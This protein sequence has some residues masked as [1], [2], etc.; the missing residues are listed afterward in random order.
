MNYIIH[1][2][3]SFA[4]VALSALI[5]IP[6]L[7]PALTLAVSPDIVAPTVS[8]T[9]PAAS[10]TVSGMVT[11]SATAADIY[12]SCVV[13]VSGSKY[14]VTPLQIGHPGGNIFVCG[15]DMTALFQSMHGSNL[16]KLAP[17]LIPASYIGVSKVEFL[18]DGT[19]VNTDM[20]SPYSFSWDSTTV[21]NGVHN[22]MAKA[23][24]QG[25]N[26]GSSAAVSV[27]VNN[28][29]PAPIPVLTSIVL[30]PASASLLVGASA[31]FSASARDQFGAALSPQPAFTWLS[32]D[33]GKATV[34]ASGLVTGVAAGSAIVTASS[35]S[36]SKTANITVT[37]PAP[38]P[39][40]AVDLSKVKIKVEMEKG[41]AEVHITMKTGPKPK[42]IE[43]KLKTS[44]KMVVVN[45]IIS[46][47][48]LTAEQVLSIAKFKIHEE[49]EDDEEEQDD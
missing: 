29:A 26:V 3:R 30:S 15:T 46:K 23:Y 6:L 27:T 21:A 49:H 20:S 22:L 18:V 5:A 33:T 44:D 1:K 12:S 2:I 37:A 19:L 32:S 10:A 11:L 28:V 4:L 47:T 42:E 9:A 8:L 7:T 31:Q 35:G 36:V 39:P 34:S 45:A 40:P 13:T 14:D 17:Y 38:V 16:A 48:G 24:D 25:G 43:F 41:K